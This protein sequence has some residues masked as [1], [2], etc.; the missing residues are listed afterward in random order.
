MKS[1]ALL[2]AAATMATAAAVA[3]APSAAIAAAPTADI[4]GTWTTNSTARWASRPTLTPSRSRAGRSPGTA[5]RISARATCTRHRRWRQGH[6]RREPR[7]PGPGARDHL[8]RADCLGRRNQ[9]QARRRRPGGRGIHRQAAGV[10]LR[11]QAFPA[12]LNRLW[13]RHDRR[14]PLRPFAHRAAACRQRAHRAAQL[15]AGAEARRA[16]PAA[17][18]RHR[19]GAQRG[20]VRRGDP[21]GPGLARARARRRGAAVGAA[22]ALRRRRS[23]GSRRRAGS[24]RLTRPRRSSISSA[25]S[26]SAAG[27]RRSTTAPRWR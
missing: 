8:H 13:G 16:L 1:I 3:V 10:A 24:I 11:N 14:H 25:R 6:L 17:D 7:L 9:V 19:R 12:A 21:R 15:A 23:S 26:R 5:S 22:G 4:S 2:F 27:C 18:R 20:A